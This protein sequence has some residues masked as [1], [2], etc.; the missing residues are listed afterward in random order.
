MKPSPNTNAGSRVSEDGPFVIIDFPDS[1]RRVITRPDAVLSTHD[2]SE[3]RDV[4]AE[5]ERAARRGARVAGF[6]TYEAAPAFEPLM[7]VAHG[8]QMPL[9]W[10]AVASKYE[11]DVIRTLAHSHTRTPAPWTLA[12]TIETYHDQ[13]EQVR[14]R[15]AAGDTYQVNL[16]ARLS[17][18]FADDP[19][20][21]YETMRR[22]QGEGYHAYIDTGAYIVASASPEL[23]FDLRGRTIRTRPMK[24]TRARGRWPAEDRGLANEL[25]AS[26]KDRAENLMIVDLLRNDLG[27][28]A[29]V[30]GVT[31]TSLFDV[32]HYRTVHQLTST[33]A[34]TVRADVALVDVFDALFPCGSITGAPKINTMRII[35]ELEP[36]PR[37]VYCG[38]VG[39]IEPDGRAVFNVPIRTVWIDKR[40]SAAVYGTGAGITYESDADTECAEIVAKAAV[41]LETWPEF[42]LL[43]TMRAE[44]GA[45]VRL[46]AH[47]ARLMTSAAYF[48]FDVDE[49]AVRTA[50]AEVAR[51]A[52]TASRVRL[53]VD[54]CGKARAETYA[55]DKKDSITAALA[56]S[57][58][59]SSDRFLFHKTTNRSVYERHAEEHSAQDDVLLWNERG[60]I[61]EF[62]RGNVVVEMAGRLLTPPLDCG[63][64]PGVFREELLRHGEI[65][66][67]VVLKEDLARVTNVWLIS[68][69]RE[70]V[71]V[72][73]F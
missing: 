70:W 23:F 39:V 14:E 34:A 41:L 45:I 53:L 58:V 20:A 3:V 44:T 69:L 68:S 32:E 17:T 55:L 43:E 11:V 31:V 9:A 52:T 8:A 33:I 60:E 13:V 25:A 19:F 63:L 61:T 7:R 47:V 38:A 2:L 28:I 65:V 30:G 29:D 62:T 67:T 15:I 27:R 37:E 56:N 49:S 22:A 35:N 57:P 66:E 18:T 50:L 71:P 24:G 6:V 26:E 12:P 59:S 72:S 40:T 46:D 16:T 5:A 73:G 42:E 1:P 51:A 21:L 4:I 48:G 36:A 54:A 10:F 64:L